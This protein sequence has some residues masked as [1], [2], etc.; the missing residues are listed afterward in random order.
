M[1]ESYAMYLHAH[2][3]TNLAH[4]N[5]SRVQHSEFSV[6]IFFSCYT[7]LCGFLSMT[8]LQYQEFYYQIVRCLEA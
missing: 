4:Q 6:C 7:L 1:Y 2:S 3:C 5:S 8:T